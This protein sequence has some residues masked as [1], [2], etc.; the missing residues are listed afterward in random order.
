VVA[1]CFAGTLIGITTAIGTFIGAFAPCFSGFLEE[2]V[3]IKM[4]KFAEGKM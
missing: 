2:K 3:E 4:H 1:A